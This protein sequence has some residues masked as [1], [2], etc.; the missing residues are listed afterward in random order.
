MEQREIFA[1]IFLFETE[2]NVY[3]NLAGQV[4]WHMHCTGIEFT[5][6]KCQWREE[7]IKV[8]VVAS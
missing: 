8:D 6:I 2:W 4:S 3:R 7:Y 1:P 5:Q